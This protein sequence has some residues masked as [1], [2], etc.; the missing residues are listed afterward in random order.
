MVRYTWSI[1]KVAIDESGDSGR[2]FWAG[3][4]PWFVVAGVIVPDVMDGCGLTCQAVS[5]YS[6]QFMQGAEIHF[7][8]NSHARHEHFLKHMQHEDYVFVAVAMDKR[9]LLKTKPYMLASK[10]AMLQY[11]LDE[12]FR[13]LQP[14]LDSPIVLIDKN[15][16]RLDRALKRHLMRLFGVKHKGDYRAIRNIRYVDSAHEPLVQLAD[17]VAGAVRHHVD[18]SYDSRSYEKYLVH[19]GKIFYL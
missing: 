8:H 17:Y 16:R 7:A 11:C 14:M 12:L 2:R 1:M 13:E 3:S 9:K 18:N 19:K 5:E 4:T 15:S 6:K 10:G